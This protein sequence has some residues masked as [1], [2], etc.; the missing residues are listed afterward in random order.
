MLDRIKT[1]KLIELNMQNVRVEP[2]EYIGF[3]ISDTE[4]SFEKI[5]NE[6]R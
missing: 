2:T 5:E 3:D 6:V 1:E 4:I